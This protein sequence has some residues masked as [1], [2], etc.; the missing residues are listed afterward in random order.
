MADRTRGPRR[1]KIWS[2]IPG[3]TLPLTTAGTSV[4]GGLAFTAAETILRMLGEYVI[5]HT[6]TITAGDSCT[7]FVGIGV[8]SS[9]AFAD[10]GA[11]AMPDPGSEPQYPW[12]Y[13]GEHKFFYPSAGAPL[14]ADGNLLVRQRIDVK[15]MRKISP[16]QT[17]ATVI[18]YS[19]VAGT[20]PM[21]VLF[22]QTRV[23]I[24]LP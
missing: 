11:S 23:L 12:L 8:V 21:Q 4:G 18:Q 2:G 9:D 15:S 5:V 19:D 1:Q 20:P 3:V 13:W 10:V 6:G 7:I 14:A 17:L 24:A 16:R 22:A